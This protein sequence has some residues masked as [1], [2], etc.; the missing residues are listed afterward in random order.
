MRRDV[1]VGNRAH[2]GL[3]HQRDALR[4]WHVVARHPKDRKIRARAHNPPPVKSPLCLS[5]R[6]NNR[7]KINGLFPLVRIRVPSGPSPPAASAP[8]SIQPFSDSRGTNPI[9]P[10]PPAVL[11]FSLIARRHFTGAAQRPLAKN[12]SKEIQAI[13]NGKCRANYNVTC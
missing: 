8:N 6:G 9:W 7:F 3:A 13:Y 1:D 10:I 2:I 5:R 4:D 11:R 12:L